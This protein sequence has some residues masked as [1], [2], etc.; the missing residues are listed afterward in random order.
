[1]AGYEERKRAMAAVDYAD[2]LVLTLRLLDEHPRVRERLSALYAWVLVDELHDVNPVQARLV[3]A[4]AGDG[5]Q[6]GR[7]GRPGPVDLLLAR[8]RPGRG[9]PVRGGPGHARLPAPDQ[10]PVDPRGGRAGPGHPAGRQPLRASACGRTGRPRAWRRW[11]RTW[12]RC[13]TRPGS[14]CSAS[15]TS[16]PPGA[17]RARWPSSTGRTTTRSTSSSAWPRPASSSSSSPERGSSRAPTSR[18]CWRS[19][20]CATTRATSWRGTGRCGSSTGWGRRWRRASGARSAPPRTPWRPPRRSRPPGPGRGG[21]HALRGRG[22][23]PSPASTR[24]E[25][26]VLLVA[27]SD[28]YRDHLQRAYRQLARPRGRPRAAGRAR[29]PRGEPRPL[30]RRPAARRAGRGRRGRV[31]APPA[32]WRSRR[33]TRRRAWS[34]RWCSCSRSSRA[35]SRRAG[36]SARATSPRRSASST[37]PSRAPPTS[38]TC[39]GRS[40]PGGPGTRAPTPWSSTRARASSTATWPG[41]VEE[42]SVR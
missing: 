40:P 20:A 26:I 4:I 12:P 14:W 24:P 16:S 25:E 34:G 9:G 22:P 29:R 18:T 38:S 8:G 27:R 5:G 7:G 30:P 13:P 31:R 35:R 21:R 33:S 6:P 1:M 42:W 23:P 10:L 36:R 3:E 2:L 19:A 41:V 17:R 32:G 11:S 39:A 15:P 37:S 28:W